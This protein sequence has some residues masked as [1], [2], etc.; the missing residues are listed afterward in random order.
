MLPHRSWKHRIWR[1]SALAIAAGVSTLLLSGRA[2]AMD[3]FVFHLDNPAG[4]NHGYFRVGRD[5]QA[6]GDARSWT[7]VQEVPFWFG[8]QDQGGDVAIADIDGDR[9]R[10]LLVLHIDNPVGENHGYYRVGWG[11]DAEGMATWGWSEP[12]AIPGWFGSED[13]GAGIAAVDVNGSG[14]PDLVVLHIDNPVG[15]NHGYYRVG[16]DVDGAGTVA[17]WSNVK[18]IPGWFGAETQGAGLAIADLDRNDRPDLV[19]F[20]IDNPAGENHGHYRIGWNLDK[21]G[22]AKSWSSPKQ[23]PGWFGAEDQGGGVALGDVDRDGRLD[24]LVFHI[25]NPGGENHGYYR[26]GY[27]L[28]DAGNVTRGWTAPKQVAGWFG[29]EDQGGGIAISP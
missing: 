26:I 29:S 11:I 1:D 7:P 18:P 23:V 10:D 20:H 5:L 2:G 6:R 13:Q 28:S 4:E 27:R 16:W 15:E 25:D 24:L 14:R 12:K 9:M 17:S 21:S 19:V 8:S 3:L 22:N